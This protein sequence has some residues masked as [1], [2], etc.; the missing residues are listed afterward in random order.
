MNTFEN[1]LQSCK[2]KLKWY[3]NMAAFGLALLTVISVVMGITMLHNS[4][5]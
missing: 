1:D 2:N 5:K 4:F 3:K